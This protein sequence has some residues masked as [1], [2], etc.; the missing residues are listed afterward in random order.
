MCIILSFS[1]LILGICRDASRY[2]CVLHFLPLYTPSFSSS[3]TSERCNYTLPCNF[4][5]RNVIARE[6]MQNMYSR[7]HNILKAVTALELSS[8]QCYHAKRVSCPDR[9]IFI[10]PRRR[11]GSILPP[12]IVFLTTDCT[13]CGVTRPYHTLAPCGKYNY[14][15]STQL[16]TKFDR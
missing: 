16:R 10:P 1:P 8:V 12:R 13:S 4:L 11:G 6:T 14:S 15:A 5:Y 9:V 3:S 7:C 2:I